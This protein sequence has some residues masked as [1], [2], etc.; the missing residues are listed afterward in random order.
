MIVAVAAETDVEFYFPKGSF[1]APGTI[2]WKEQSV[3]FKLVSEIHIAFS[4]LAY[5]RFTPLPASMNTLPM[6]YPPICAFSTIGECPGL[7]TFLGWFTLL[8]LIG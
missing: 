6:S 5:I 7:G 2:P 1:A 8:N 3:G 4:V